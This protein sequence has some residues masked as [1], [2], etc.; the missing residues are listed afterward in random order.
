L[1]SAG[2]KYSD[3]HPTYLPPPDARAAFQRG[4]VDAWAIWDPFFVAAQKQIGARVLT[5][6]MGLAKR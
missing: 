5:N 2:L 4:S 1:A 3:I 6:A